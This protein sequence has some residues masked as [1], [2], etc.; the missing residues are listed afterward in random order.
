MRVQFE[1]NLDVG[2]EINP[3]EGLEKNCYLI[4][5]YL[6]AVFG[7]SK[8]AMLGPD[9]SHRRTLVKSLVRNKRVREEIDNLSGLSLIH[10]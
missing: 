10:I 4:T 7:K 1:N 3:G 5:R 8:K 6:R 2:K 9:I